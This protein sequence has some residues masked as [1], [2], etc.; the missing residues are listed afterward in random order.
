MESYIISKVLIKRQDIMQRS[1]IRFSIDII[2]FTQ[3]ESK[4]RCIHLCI[5]DLEILLNDSMLKNRCKMK[6]FSIG[7]IPHFTLPAGAERSTVKILGS[8]PNP[9]SGLPV[10][11]VSTTRGVALTAA[12]APSITG[13]YSETVSVA[14]RM[15]MTSER[16]PDEGYCKWHMKVPKNSRD[17]FPGI[18]SVDFS[19]NV[20]M[21]DSILESVDFV[22]EEKISTP[23]WFGIF[24]I[25]KRSITHKIVVNCQYNGRLSEEIFD[26]FSGTLNLDDKDPKIH[27]NI[28]KEFPNTK[29]TITNDT[30]V[31]K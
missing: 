31:N 26:E 21:M 3:R 16:S 15:V 30:Y 20:H 28:V 29:A 23:R 2:P 7:I 8:S 1:I 6:E 4:Q 27:S 9:Y 14:P 17:T 18:A 19:C 13:G 10:E 5:K 12:M 11:H 24:P 22:V 25:L